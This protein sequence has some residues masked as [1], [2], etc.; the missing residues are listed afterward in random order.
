[1]RNE[2]TLRET[3]VVSALLQENTLRAAAK[4]AGV[5]ERTVYR[6]VRLARVQK[7]LR[8][9]R[10]ELFSV[11]LS[12]LRQAWSLTGQTLAKVMSD[13]KTSGAAKV[14]A[15]RTALRAGE[16]ARMYDELENRVADLEQSEDE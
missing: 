2:L 5:S 11:A 10:G 13:A 3:R 6:Y 8:R 16:T 4:R 14:S 12:G 7:E 15:A 9:Q 1:M